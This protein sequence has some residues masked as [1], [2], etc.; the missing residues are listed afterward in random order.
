MFTEIIRLLEHRAQ[1]RWLIVSCRWDATAAVPV[2]ARK[3]IGSVLTAAGLDASE[4]HRC[5]IEYCQDR[6]KAVC[7]IPDSELVAPIVALGQHC[8]PPVSIM[9]FRNRWLAS[10][11]LEGA[12][13]GVGTDLVEVDAGVDCAHGGVQCSVRVFSCVRSCRSAESGG[14]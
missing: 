12:H 13:T 5:R 3:K 10:P 8:E 11:G 7:C 14:L 2:A 6:H 4:N 1:W 9:A